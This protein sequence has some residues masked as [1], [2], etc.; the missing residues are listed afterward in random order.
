MSGPLPG[1]KF[2]VTADIR[3]LLKAGY[4][5]IEGVDGQTIFVM[6]SVRSYRGSL[7]FI[8]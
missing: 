6:P 5:P 7:S 1:S 8:F 4:I 3:N 2:E